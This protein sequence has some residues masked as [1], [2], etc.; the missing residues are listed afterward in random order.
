MHTF[1]K[2]ILTGIASVA[3]AVGLSGC[4]NMESAPTSAQA[5]ASEV[6]PSGVPALWRIADEDTTIYVFGTVHTLP[7]NIDWYT[8]PVK[9]A[10]DASETL[11]T[12]IDMTPESMAKVPAIIQQT[13]M[14]PAGTTLRSLMNEEDLKTFEAAMA[15]LNLPVNAVDQLEPWFATL[16]LSNI[17]YS[18]AGFNPDNGTENVL[19]RTVGDSLDRGSLETIESQFA[20]FDELPQEAQIEYLIET[21]E[22]IDDIAPFLQS[23]V[24]EWAEGDVQELGNLLND[25][26]EADPVLANRLL[27]ARNANWA[28]WIDDRLDQPGTIF[29]AVGAGHMAGNQ[30][31]QDKLAERGITMNRIQ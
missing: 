30:K 12:E 27:Y 16:Q 24:D 15:K 31:L 18:A 11:V 4:A 6:G 14:L 13:A 7:D 19:E 23:M 5:P 26:L 28:V 10:L 1:R 20:I 21:L 29:M 17:A 2:S 25:A 22:Q 9:S 3:L 8:G